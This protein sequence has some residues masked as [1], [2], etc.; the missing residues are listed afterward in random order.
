VTI[1]VA[2]QLRLT[3]LALLVLSLPSAAQGKWK[4]V[5]SD[6]FNGPANSAPD[7]AKWV[8]DLG[9]GG[10]GNNEL[11]T[12]THDLENAHVDGE[13]N[14]VIRA[15]RSEQRY[16]SAR[17]K[18][19]G[20]FAVTFGKI[21]A[22]MKLPHGQG[23]WPAFW[24]L[25]A[26]ISTAHWP[27]CGE[28]DIMEQIG[29]EPSKVHGTLHGPDYSGGNGITAEFSLPGN[30]KFSDRF[31]TFSVVWT[32]A[33][34]EFLVDSVSYA[35]TSAEDL[36]EKKWVFNKPFFLLLN[37]AVGGNWPKNPDASTEFPQTMTVDY[38]R[39]YQAEE[40]PAANITAPADTKR[41][42][43]PLHTAADWT[44]GNHLP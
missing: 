22:R 39:V 44:D 25:G 16:T 34:V 17:L 26:D 27:T 23:L 11:E 15:L 38:I 37:L 6:E 41:A 1:L 29:K 24:M 10:W 20:K 36:K 13:G 40:I 33:S 7:P 28:I 35:K 43:P 14:L 4:L 9:A 18:T 12:Y 5:W 19:Q 42:F 30:E 3:V 31:H 21:E 2:M 32:P 8:Y